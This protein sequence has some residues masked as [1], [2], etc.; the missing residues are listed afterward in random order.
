MSADYKELYRKQRELNDQQWNLI[1]MLIERLG[2][3]VRFSDVDFRTDITN[4][5]FQLKM[6]EDTLLKSRVYTVKRVKKS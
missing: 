4:G 2:G 5:N 1:C 6:H 3:Q